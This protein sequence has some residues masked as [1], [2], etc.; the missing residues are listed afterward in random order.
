ML[1]LENGNFTDESIVGIEI[2]YVPEKKGYARQN[3]LL[4]V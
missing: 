3:G 1:N 2:L 4:Q